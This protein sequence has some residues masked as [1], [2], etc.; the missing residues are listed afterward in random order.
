M[1]D[2][3]FRR[4]FGDDF[5]DAETRQAERRAELRAKFKAEFMESS[6]AYSN[7]NKISQ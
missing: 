6:A 3:E 4:Y 7:S 2:D 1:T 5:K